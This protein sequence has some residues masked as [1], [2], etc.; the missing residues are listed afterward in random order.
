MFKVLL[1]WFKLTAH[2]RQSRGECILNHHLKVIN[3]VCYMHH[4]LL[5]SQQPIKSILLLSQFYRW[6]NWCLER[7]CFLARITDL[8]FERVWFQSLFSQITL[9][10]WFPQGCL[11]KAL[12]PI[13][14]LISVRVSLL[15]IFRSLG[16]IQWPQAGKAKTSVQN[17]GSQ[18]W[19]HVR[20]NWGDWKR[21]EVQITSIR[22]G[23]Q[24]PGIS[25]ELVNL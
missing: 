2:G 12:L 16:D 23:K 8:I 4:L 17:S 21:P 6:G 19:L 20:M 11:W 7:L 3:W 18:P 5:S 1:R 15:E 14:P 22:I 10:H 9:Q 13:P 25:D 24:S